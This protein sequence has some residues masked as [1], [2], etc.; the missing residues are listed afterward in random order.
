MQV[1]EEETT[2]GKS[3]LDT[4]YATLALSILMILGIASFAV[5]YFAFKNRKS[6]S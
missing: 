6:Q 2:F 5:Y 1:E 3:E 4:L